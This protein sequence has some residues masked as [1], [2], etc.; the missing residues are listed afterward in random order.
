MATHKKLAKQGSP[1]QSKEKRKEL[2]KKQTLSILLA[3]LM[4]VSL[5]SIFAA[6]RADSNNELKYN[7]Y[8]FEPIF[9]SEYNMYTY[10]TKINKDLYTF[11]S[12]PQDTLSIFSAGNLTKLFDDAT[13]VIISKEDTSLLAPIFDEIHFD[14]ANT[15]K[16]SF[17]GGI[18]EATT[19][20]SVHL[21]K[22]C[23]DATKIQPVIILKEGV[24]ADLDINDY[25]A[26]F[27]ITQNT[28]ALA[29]DRLMYSL[30]GVILN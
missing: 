26:T 16:K 28:G 19:N 25:C 8:S 13:L 10:T 30:L 14:L 5:F 7:G 18:L 15:N 4:L 3:V 12:L 27:T 23:D 29:R 6:Q 17:V 22:T 2:R 20:E 21:Q 11:Y 24:E 9:Q 1:R